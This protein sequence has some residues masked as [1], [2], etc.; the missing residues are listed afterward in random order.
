MKDSLSFLI[1]LL[2]F[3]TILCGVHYY[4]VYNFLAESVLYFPLWTIYLFNAVMVFVVY[5]IVSYKVSNGSDKAFQIFLGL[6]SVKMLL[7]IIFLLPVFM[8]K[9]ENKTLEAFNFFIPYFFFLGFEIF[10]L[11][12]FF[13]NLETK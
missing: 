1:K 2:L 4:M 10:A 9:A 13:Q 8:G 6:T 3:S 5:F 11:N 7:A 12:K